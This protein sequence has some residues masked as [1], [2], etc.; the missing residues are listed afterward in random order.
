MIAVTI[1]GIFRAVQ[2]PLQRKATHSPSASS[3]Y[4]LARVAVQTLEVRADQVPGGQRRSRGEHRIPNLRC[5]FV[6]DAKLAEFEL[7]LSDP[8]HELDAS[9][10][11]SEIILGSEQELFEIIR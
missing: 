5:G 2:I 9:D 3:G 4:E 11:L 6:F 8:M 7:T 10:R 1:A